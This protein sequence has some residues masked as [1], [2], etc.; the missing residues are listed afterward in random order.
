MLGS[1]TPRPMKTNSI[2]SNA[3][4]TPRGAEPFE[5]GREPLDPQHDDVERDTGRDFEHHRA[6]VEVGRRQDMPEVPVAPEVDEHRKA[7][8]RV[9]EYRG[10]QRRAYHRMKLAAVEDVDQQRHGVAAAGKAGGDDHI[11]HDPDAPGVAVVDV[12]DGA[13]AVHEALERKK[14]A[15]PMSSDKAMVSRLISLPP[16][17]SCLLRIL[18]L[19]GM[20]VMIRPPHRRVAISC[21]KRPPA[22]GR[23][24]PRRERSGRCR[25]F[26]VRSR[27]QMHRSARAG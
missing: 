6:G 8:E 3:F 18:G 21:R 15:T 14:S 12:G 17:A 23:R 1:R 16:I 22:Q 19:M 7:A 11:P 25:A 10:G 4:W 9:T 2:R 5:E 26:P 27:I 24:A 13:E 20:S